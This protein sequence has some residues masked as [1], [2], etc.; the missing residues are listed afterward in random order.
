LKTWIYFICGIAIACLSTGKARADAQ[1]LFEDNFT[2]LDPSLSVDTGTQVKDGKLEM[3]MTAGRFERY[4]Y[5][6]GFFTDADISLTVSST[7]GDSLA[8]S[9]GG[10]IFW[11]IDSSNFYVACVSPD[12]SSNIFRYTGG[13]WLIPASVPASPAVHKGTGAG[14]LLRVVTKGN[15][16]TFYI[17]GVQMTA[18]TGMPPAGGG[19]V[20]I[21][22]QSDTVPTT[23]TAQ[24]FKVLPL[25]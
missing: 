18:I 24:D 20:G 16:A 6:V 4:L 9:E 21:Y 13:R 23:W 1:P 14:N 22:A 17:N 15:R 10:I 12:G 8:N 2:T 7:V 19:L 25:Q 3:A 11:G 5:Q